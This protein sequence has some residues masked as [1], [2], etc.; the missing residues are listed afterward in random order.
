[1]DVAETASQG[2][3][4]LR[5]S[6]RERGFAYSRIVGE[7][8]HPGLR[9]GDVVLLKPSEAPRPGDIVTFALGERLVTHRVV[10]V[11]SS[12]ITC[13]GDNRLGADPPVARG[14][15]IARVVDVVGRTVPDGP[16]CLF[17]VRAHWLGVDWRRRFARL[18][19]EATLLGGSLGGRERGPQ[20]PQALRAVTGV[21]A[22]DA[23]TGG[24]VLQAAETAD[25]RA[26]L[27]GHPDEL[28]VFPA[29]VYGGMPSSKRREVMQAVR[30][31]RVAVYGL[32][33]ASAGRITHLT[34]CVRG[35]LRAHGF[36]DGEPGDMAVRD[37][38]GLRS[39]H[40]FTAAELEQEVERFGLGPVKVETVLTDSG[41]LLRATAGPA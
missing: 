27:E 29:D 40:T 18:R 7:S 12:T 22:T 41:P 26:L 6:L 36:K 32:P 28:L 17:R 21:T 15:V 5:T 19:D 9:S 24:H 16:L 38:A 33:R 20:V 31:H 34:T 3:S 30:G 35:S 11:G 10:T 23:G 13:R 25:P 1:M 39:L 37:G 14:A 4:A 2:E 8:M